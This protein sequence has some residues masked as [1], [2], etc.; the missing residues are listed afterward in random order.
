MRIGYWLV[1]QPVRC[2]DGQSRRAALDV[3]LLLEGGR[4][5]ER[6]TERR[7]PRPTWG[8]S[9]P[10]PREAHPCPSTRGPAATL[11]QRTSL[12]E[13]AFFCDVVG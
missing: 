12:V 2:F 10:A 13:P 5:T 1:S 8:Q 11:P 7:Q 6:R 3:W 9:N 4:R